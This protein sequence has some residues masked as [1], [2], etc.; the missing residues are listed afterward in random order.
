MKEYQLTV[1]DVLEKKKSFENNKQ[2]IEALLKKDFKPSR[3]GVER[4][5]DENGSYTTIVINKDNHNVWAHKVKYNKNF[6][7]SACV[8]SIEGET[9]KKLNEIY[10]FAIT[11][12]IFKAAELIGDIKVLKHEW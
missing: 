3:F 7:Y 4:R 5:E 9:P 2:L 10:D 6:K 12:D 11:D 1:F 8:D